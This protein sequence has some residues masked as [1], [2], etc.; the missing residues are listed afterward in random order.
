MFLEYRIHMTLYSGVDDKVL[1]DTL[2]EDFNTF[3][4][5]VNTILSKL[6]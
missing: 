2:D 1:W 3:E 5:T 4:E 6:K